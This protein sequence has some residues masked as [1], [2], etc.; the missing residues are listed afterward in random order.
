MEYYNIYGTTCFIYYYS[1]YQVGIYM[2][3]LLPSESVL[4]GALHLQP[5][6][7]TI[8]LIYSFHGSLIVMKQ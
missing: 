3:L 1:E 6:H 4:P 8:H 7:K 2:I 5:P